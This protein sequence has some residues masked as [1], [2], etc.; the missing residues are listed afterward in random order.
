MTPHPRRPGRA[1]GRKR[2]RRLMVKIG[3]AAIHQG[4]RSSIPHLEHRIY[5]HSLCNLVAGRPNQ[6]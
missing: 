4:P 1:V 5:R 6:V 3:L 2:V